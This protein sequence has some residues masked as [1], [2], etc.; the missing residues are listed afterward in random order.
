MTSITLDTTSAKTA[1]EVGDT[2]DSSDVVVTAHY[3]DS[4]SK[5]VSALAT[6][7]G[8]NMSTR[9]N[10]TVT[11]SYTEGDVT[12]TAS[13][14]ITVHQDIDHITISGQTTSFTE[15]DEFGIGD[16]VVMAYYD[17]LETD[18]VD[19]TASASF[20]PFDIGDELEE[21]DDGT[22]ITVSYDGQTTTYDISVHAASGL[23]GYYRYTNATGTVYAILDL[24]NLSY[25]YVN[26]GSSIDA[27]YYLI[28]SN[29]QV[30]GDGKTSFVISLDTGSSSYTSS[31]VGYNLF[32]GPDNL[33]NSTPRISADGNTLTVDRYYST[34]ASGNNKSGTITLT[35]TNRP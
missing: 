25:R 31:F 29:V 23:S 20:S 32:D 26:S 6:F 19:V 12:K 27:T 22:T 30:G 8:Y 17:A 13:Y 24:D 15:G 14:G 16:G 33:T 3:D 1:Y 34:K 5:D 2:F 28:F 21:S 11:V 35:K 10:Q 18:G 7:S 4:T 9:G